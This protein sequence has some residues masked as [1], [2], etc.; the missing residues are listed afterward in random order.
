M[1]VRQVPTHA[2]HRVS[3]DTSLHPY[4]AQPHGGVNSLPITRQKTEM[5]YLDIASLEELNTPLANIETGDSR[6]IGRVE[7]YSCT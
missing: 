4:A 1:A 6:I 7:A 2:T 5:K 3:V